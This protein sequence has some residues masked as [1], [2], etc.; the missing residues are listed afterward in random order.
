MT[1]HGIQKTLS[2]NDTGATGGHQAG[3]LVPK[4]GDVL[5]FFPRLDPA[6]KNPRAVIGVVDDTGHE[7]AFSF[8]YYNNRFFGGTRNEYRLTGMTAFFRQFNLKPGDTIVLHRE[9]D[10]LIRIRFERAQRQATKLRLS[11]SWKVIETEF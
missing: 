3:V 1:P 11:S 2:A 9:A 4:G 7:W 8:I 5:R 10:R 6:C